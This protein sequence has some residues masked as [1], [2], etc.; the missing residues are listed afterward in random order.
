MLSQRRMR[1]PTCWVGAEWD[2]PHA[3]SAQNEI[4]HM[5]S[6]VSTRNDR[7]EILDM[8]VRK[9]TYNFF[10]RFQ[11]SW[12]KPQNIS[13]LFIRIFNNTRLKRMHIR[14]LH[15]QKSMHIA[16]VFRRIMKYSACRV[17]NVQ[18]QLHVSS[19]LIYFAFKI[20]NIYNI[21]IHTDD[22]LQRENV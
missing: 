20:Y 11:T 21:T 15:P 14:G 12:I 13:C 5:L 22:A 7:N 2:S 6:A 10:S 18:I 19:L 17:T 9:K 3:E 8:R 1:F 16:Q 4:R